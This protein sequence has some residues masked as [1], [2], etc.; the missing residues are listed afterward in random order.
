MAARAR[1]G[2]SGSLQAPQAEGA[3]AN[4]RAAMRLPVHSPQASV[5]SPALCGW[6]DRYLWRSWRGWIKVTGDRLSVLAWSGRCQ[7]LCLH[8]RRL[9]LPV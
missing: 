5:Q 2:A 4:S 3:S 6:L 7:R 9:P 8:L 1:F